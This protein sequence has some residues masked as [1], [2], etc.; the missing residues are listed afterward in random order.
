MGHVFTSNF[1]CLGRVAARAERRAGGCALIFLVF[2]FVNITSIAGAPGCI[3]L[4]V[5]PIP[6]PRAALF[7]A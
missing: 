4:L 3:P 6:P 1:F 2:I 7:G 5:G